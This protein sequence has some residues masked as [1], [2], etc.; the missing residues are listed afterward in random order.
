MYLSEKGGLMFE[1]FKCK[2]VV[3]ERQQRLTQVL[4]LGIEWVSAIQGAFLHTLD[5]LF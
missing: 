2:E 3:S 4:C 5:I 1:F